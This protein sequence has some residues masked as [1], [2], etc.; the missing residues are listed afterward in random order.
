DN[1][2]R[3]QQYTNTLDAELRYCRELGLTP[4]ANFGATNCYPDTPL[5]GDITKQHPDWR[6]GHALRYDVPEVREYIL[7]LCREALEIGAPGISIDFC[8]Y[9]DGVDKAETAT[10]FMR[11][12]RKLADEFGRTTGKHVPILVR[13]PAKGVRKWQCFD[14][15]T[16]AREGLVDYLCPSN[17]Q[18]RHHHFDIKPYIEAVKG[19]KCKLTPC[20]DGLS[21]GLTVP[22]MFLQRAKQLYDA[23]VDGVYLYQAD[24]L[25]LGNMTDRRCVRLLGSSEAVRRWWEADRQ[26][27]P[28]HSKGIY[29][30]PPTDRGV[31][32]AWERLRVWPEGIPFGS[33]EMYLD[34]KLISRYDGPPYVLGTEEYESDGVIPPGEHTLL[35]RARDGDGWLE[36]KSTVRGAG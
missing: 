20:V 29:I 25:V 24:A 22:G 15:K 12:L 28:K 9:P 18:G 10:E 7:S 16:W 2:G 5:Q 19:T 3:M 34:G 23:G 4:H 32:N 14:Y 26:E 1:V 30:K 27:R 13:F 11:S 31:Y 36:Q 33:L 35:I 21:W 17:L 6:T 8:R